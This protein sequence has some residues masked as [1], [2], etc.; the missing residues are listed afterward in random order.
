MAGKEEHFVDLT[1]LVNWLLTNDLSTVEEG[2]AITNITNSSKLKES[3][4]VKY[5][6]SRGSTSGDFDELTKE[7]LSY[8]LKYNIQ[9][10]IGQD[11]PWFFYD[12]F[13]PHL[14]SELPEEMR[15]KWFWTIVEEHPYQLIEALRVLVA[16]K[17][18]KGTCPVCQSL[19]EQA[20][21]EGYKENQGK[22]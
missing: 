20:E 14:L 15:N 6:I 8:L 13:V 1:N 10:A 17:T 22:G 12:C 2:A 9:F 7:Q 19:L 11:M 4:Q 5:I 21:V 18:F 16:R 3:H